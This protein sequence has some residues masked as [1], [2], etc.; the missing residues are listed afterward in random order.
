MFSRTARSESSDSTS[1]AEHHGD[2]HPRDGSA[3][4]ERLR[5]Q[6]TF[7]ASRDVLVATGS[8][9]TLSFGRW[10]PLNHAVYLDILKDDRL[11]RIEMFPEEQLGAALRRFAE[12]TSTFGTSDA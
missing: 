7:R 11:V 6:E 9:W 2:P 5:L 4:G 1:A 3:W 12:L 10:E 8:F